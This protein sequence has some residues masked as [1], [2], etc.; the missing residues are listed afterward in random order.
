VADCEKIPGVD[1]RTASAARV[2]DVMLGGK[3]NFAA[4]RELAAQLLSNA[5]I[6]AWIAQ[7][8]RAF[9]G[10]A[11]RYCAEQ[12]VRQFLDLGSGLPTQE[13]VHEVAQRVDGT[14]RV[15]YVDSDPVAV[16]HAHALL[17][18]GANVAAIQGDLRRPAEIIAHRD[19]ERLID[20]SQPVVVLMVAVL[21][22]VRD[23]EDPAGV[24]S[25]LTDVMAPGS[26]LV[27]SHATH[28]T[29]PEEA[30]RARGLYQRASAPLVTRTRQQIAGLFEGLDLVEPGL[31]LTTGWRP[32]EEIPGAERAG[33]YAGV[34]RKRADQRRNP[35]LA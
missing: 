2:Y 14:C 4:D 32:Q 22:F 26:Y 12:G 33:L 34:A 16:S 9:L 20:F 1:P 25:R 18:G 13:N 30:S 29:R 5:P 27:L 8:N 35:T 3:D 19:V 6:S 15:V 31:V 10:R 7:Q 11:V 28:D 17:A 23:D 24:I 21:H